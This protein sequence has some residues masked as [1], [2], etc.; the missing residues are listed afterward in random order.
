MMEV[1]ARIL[2]TIRAKHDN[3]VTISNFQNWATVITS[4]GIIESFRILN[5]VYKGISVATKC[6]KVNI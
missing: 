2:G 5:I 3:G 6:T 1:R 4:Q